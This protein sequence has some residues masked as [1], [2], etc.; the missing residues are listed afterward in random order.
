MLEACGRAGKTQQAEETIAEFTCID[1]YS[2]F[3]A[4]IRGACQ[5]A[6]VDAALRFFRRLEKSYT[7]TSYTVA[8]LIECL[9]RANRSAAAWEI[10][11]EHWAQDEIVLESMIRGLCSNH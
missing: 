4:I 8:P 10:F 7:M 1:Q 11:N 3:S 9:F 2:A 6:K 5:G